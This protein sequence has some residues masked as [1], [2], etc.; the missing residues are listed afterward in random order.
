LNDLLI[1]LLLGVLEGLTEFLPVSSTGHLLI[2]QHWLGPESDL[3]NIVIQSGAILAVLLVFRA[4]LWALANG[5]R[6]RESQDYLLKLGVA[7]AVTA[8][9][10]LPVRQLGWALPETVWPVATALILGGI[11]MIVIERYVERRSARAVVTAER[12]DVSASAVASLSASMPVVSWN[13]AIWV[14]LAQVLAGVFPGT[15]RS[16]AAIFAAM[17]AGLWSRPAAAEFAFLLAI[18]TMFAASA[19]ALLEYARNPAAPREDWM[20]LGVAFVAAALTGFVVVRWLLAYVKSQRFTVFAVYRIV[21]GAGLLLFL[22]G[23]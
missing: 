13:V 1:A 4:R 12:G 11:A 21:L 23:Q 18:P 15:S 2:A 6:E 17:L 8:A 22:P 7:F 10:G 3:F 20:A 19:Y 14:G 16:A 5:W 9:V